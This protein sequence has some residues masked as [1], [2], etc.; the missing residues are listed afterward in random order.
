MLIG[1]M[2]T[3]LVPSAVPIIVYFLSGTIWRMNGP[4]PLKAFVI[5]HF[6]I[7]NNCR[8]WALKGRQNIK[9]ILN[10]KRPTFPEIQ[11]IWQ[12]QGKNVFYSCNKKP[13]GFYLRPWK[14]AHCFSVQFKKLLKERQS[15]CVATDASCLIQTF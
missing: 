7:N 1:Y 15:F 13:F 12:Y 5:L 3:P 8:P 10:K 9:Q 14:W 11:K 2:K 4:C 6:C